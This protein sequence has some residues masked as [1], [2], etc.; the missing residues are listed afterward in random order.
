MRSALMFCLLVLPTSMSWAHGEDKP[1]PSGGH[2]RM[3]GGFHTELTLDE[4]QGAHI[5]LLDI[6]FAHPTVK[7]SKIEMK[8][9]SG[10]SEI[11]FRCDVMGGDHFHCVPTQKYPAKK[12]ELRVL[13]T[14]EKSRGQEAIYKLPLPPFKTDKKS[15][16]ETHHGH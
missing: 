15:D 4:Q 6:N 2:I 1:G 16:H 3:P 10:K 14:R 12:G 7:D 11:P 9:V 13:A 5:F 8:W